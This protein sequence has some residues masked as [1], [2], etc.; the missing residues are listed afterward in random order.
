MLKQSDI[1]VCYAY[2]HLGG[3]GQM[4]EKAEK[5]GKRIINIA[6]IRF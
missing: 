2:H 1:V 6:K 3:A 5:Q 4:V